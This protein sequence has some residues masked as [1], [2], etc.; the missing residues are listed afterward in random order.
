MTAKLDAN[1]YTANRSESR[2][3]MQTVTG[4]NQWANTKGEMTT[5]R[6]Q[7]T[8]DKGHC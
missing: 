5:D 3:N 8:G 1:Q 2:G 6:R 7:F 4:H